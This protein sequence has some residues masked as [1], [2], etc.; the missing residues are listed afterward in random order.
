VIKALNIDKLRFDMGDYVLSLQAVSVRVG[1]RE[2]LRCVD[3]DVKR[4]AFAALVG[5]A[6]AGKS[7][8]L[9]CIAGARRAARGRVRYFGYEIRSFARE[10]IARLGI[11]GTQSEPQ[12]FGTMSVLDT[13]VV[14]ALLRHPRIGKA[15]ARAR[16]VLALTGL[17]E[18]AMLPFAAL[19]DVDR[20]RLEVARALATDPQV[21][22]LDDIAAGLDRAGIDALTTLLARA[23]TTGLTVVA[24]A[25]TLDRIPGR[26]DAV[27]AIEGGRTVELPA[28]A[29][30]DVRA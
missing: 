8:T 29:P 7:L 14:G 11:V 17:T 28:A 10:R 30:A 19:G 26:P 2:R 23:R 27:S 16:D 22:L 25:R 9:A 20:K 24:A 5:S 3:L 13:V 1:G 4:G 21:L 18:R 15:R 6:G 12:P